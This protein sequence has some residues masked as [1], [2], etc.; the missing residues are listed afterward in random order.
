MKY[1]WLLVSN[2]VS[3]LIGIENLENDVIFILF[4][5]KKF[6]YLCGDGFIFCVCCNFFSLKN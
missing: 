4:F 2:M 6:D 1:V 3:N 5:L